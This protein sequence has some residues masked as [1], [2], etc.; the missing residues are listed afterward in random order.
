MDRYIESNVNLLIRLSRE[1]QE[2]DIDVRKLNI[3]VKAISAAMNTIEKYHG[4]YC[5]QYITFVASS[6]LGRPIGPFNMH[7]AT[8]LTKNNSILPYSLIIKSQIYETVH[9]QNQYV[10]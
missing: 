8:I 3:Y 9:K 2:P 7:I 10:S 6:R 1:A 5:L 4:L